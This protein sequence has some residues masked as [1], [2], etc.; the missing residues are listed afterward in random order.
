[1]MA[2][3]DFGDACASGDLE[4]AKQLLLKH[5]DKITI[6]VMEFGFRKACYE[7]QADVVEWILK[8]APEVVSIIKE[9]IDK[10]FYAVCTQGHLNIAKIILTLKPDIDTTRENEDP[11]VV[12]CISGNLELAKW[13]LSVRPDTDISFVTTGNA[14][15]K[16][17]Y[18]V[19]HDEVVEWLEQVMTER[20]NK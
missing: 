20:E 10:L 13:L 15:T 19:E 4:M 7:G 16:I 14:K 18:D 9:G 5:P 11:F 2:D 17:L 12:A 1:M 6:S 8:T 3:F